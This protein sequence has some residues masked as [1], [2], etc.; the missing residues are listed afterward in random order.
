VQTVV[1]RRPLGINI[2]VAKD[3]SRMLIFTD[4]FKLSRS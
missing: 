3:H 4:V 1:P 2:A